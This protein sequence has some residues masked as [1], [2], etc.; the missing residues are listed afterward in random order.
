VL[1]RRRSKKRKEQAELKRKAEEAA[2]S[3]RARSV[4]VAG[5][6]AKEAGPAVAKAAGVVAAKAGPAVAVVGTK[7]APVAKAAGDRVSSGLERVREDGKVRTYVL[8]GLAGAWFL[9]RLSEWRQLRK[10]NRNLATT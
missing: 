8:A 2:K 6:V 7:A 4:R 9:F 10:L 3:V 1:A 5:K